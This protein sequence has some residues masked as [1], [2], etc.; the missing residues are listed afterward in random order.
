MLL[1]VYATFTSSFVQMFV[2][3]SANNIIAGSPT[4]CSLFTCDSVELGRFHGEGGSEHV[5]SMEPRAGFE[6]SAA[7]S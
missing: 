2:V 4:D 1:S 6:G 3:N 7:Q 5:I